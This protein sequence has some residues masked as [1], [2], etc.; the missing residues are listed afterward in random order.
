LSFYTEGQCKESMKN[1]FSIWKNGNYDKILFTGMGS[2]Y[3]ISYAATCLL[4]KHGITS[5]AI[6]AGEL[7]HYQFSLVNKKTLLVCISQSGE[8][9]E[10]VKILEKLPQDVTSI[11]IS[12][13]AN[14]TLVKKTKESLLCKAG[15][16]DMT[17]TK[18][19]TTTYLATYLLSLSLT[20]NFNN[21][22]ISEIEGAIKTVGDLL[23][24]K[25]KWLDGAVKTIAH[26]PFVQLVGRGAI[27]ATV[28]QSALM[29]MEATRTPASALYG[30]E[31]RHGPMEMV[32]EGFRAVVFAPKG[33]TY[34]QSIVVTQDILKFGGKVLLITNEETSIKNENLFSII[35]PCANEDLF[36]IPGVIP[37]QLIVN[38]WAVES[39]NEPGNFT[40]G[41]KV[42]IIE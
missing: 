26:V 42:T 11:G 33:I 37:M 19:F 31:F 25:D 36:A 40:R 1:I 35:I 8:S 5:F 39:G 28:S 32:K 16:E 27:Y 14:S 22:T 24:Q 13:E 18:T 34:E 17:S 23:D 30:G 20:G 2:S 41:A 12:N 29:F 38:Q 15:P 7:L 6:N 21:N 3:F 4:N 10:I 9:Y